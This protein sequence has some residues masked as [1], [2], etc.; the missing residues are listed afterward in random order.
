[1]FYAE[2]LFETIMNLEYRDVPYQWDRKLNNQESAKAIN[3]KKF[4]N[5]RHKNTI[6]TELDSLYRDL[7]N[8]GSRLDLTVERRIEIREELTLIRKQKR[9]NMKIECYV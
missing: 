1:M 3:E 9:M 8:E 6:T 2:T 5:R 4:I 7:V